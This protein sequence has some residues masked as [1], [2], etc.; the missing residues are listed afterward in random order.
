MNCCCSCSGRFSGVALVEW[1]FI[2]AACVSNS[3][4]N[5]FDNARQVT[6]E[7]VAPKRFG[8][9]KKS[10]STIA[11]VSLVMQTHLPL[12]DLGASFLCA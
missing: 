3:K 8:V 1:C 5:E 11:G 9:E 4:A 12:A 7:W 6:Q 2:E 10:E